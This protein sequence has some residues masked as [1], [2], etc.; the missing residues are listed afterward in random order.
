MLV[1]SNGV[2]MR[3]RVFGLMAALLTSASMAL[4]QGSGN[5]APAK[6]TTGGAPMQVK[7]TAPP[8][9]ASQMLRP[10]VTLDPPSRDLGLNDPNKVIRTQF[11]L[12]NTSQTTLKLKEIRVACSCTQG[13]L[14]PTT[15]PAGATATLDVALDLRGSLGPLKKDLSVFFEGYPTPVAVNMTGSMSYP[16]RVDP[17]A[18]T[19]DMTYRQRLTLDSIDGKPFKVLAINGEKPN[20]VSSEPAGGER[21]VKWV[22]DY[23]FT[24]GKMPAVLVIETDHP[25][26]P[27]VDVQVHHQ[28][29]SDREFNDYIK[30]SYRDVFIMRKGLNVGVMHKG[31]PMEFN[32]QL[33]LKDIARAK[34]VTVR[35]DSDEVDVEIVSFNP[36]KPGPGAEYVVRVTPKTDR[37]GFFLTPFYFT[38]DDKVARIWGAGVF[39]KGSGS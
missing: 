13:T 33:Q 16:V 4:A 34:D 6:P 9:N 23:Q 30:D 11:T 35:T 25:D 29:V 39:R 1:A 19:P 7:P 14:N 17:P 5:P 3:T 31:K 22:L 24:S 15:I 12:R 18:S 27:V 28:E 10:P 2:V 36:Y 8:P 32:V 21:A 26:A 20:V 38:L 37:E